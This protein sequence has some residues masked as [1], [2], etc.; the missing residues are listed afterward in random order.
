MMFWGPREGGV[1]KHKRF[2]VSREAEVPKHEWFRVSGEGGSAKT[3]VV[4]AVR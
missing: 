4:L 1:P 3:Q 2:R